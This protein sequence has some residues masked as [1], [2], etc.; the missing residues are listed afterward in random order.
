M[1][2]LR[3]IA[4]VSGYTLLSRVTGFIRDIL[5]AGM[6]GAGTVSDAFFVAFRFPNLFRRLFAEGAFQAAFVPIFAG[7]IETD[8]RAA[9]HLFARRA[10]SVLAVILLVFT[11][12]LEVFMPVV[13]VVIAPGFDAVPGKMELATE[14]TRIAFPYLLFISLVSLQSGV[15]NSLGYFAAAAAAPILLNLTL[16]AALIGLTPVLE[17]SGHALAW[18]V[19]AAGV[20]QFA[21]L[22]WHCRRVGMTLW[23]V[24]PRLTERVRLLGKRVVPVVLGGSLYQINLLI[25]TILASLLADGAV[26]WLYYADRVTQLPLGVVGVAVSTALLPALSRRLKAGDHTAARNDQNRALEVALLLT[27]P[28]AAALMVIPGPVIGTLFERG[29]FSKAD[30][31]ATAGALVAFAT[32]LPSYVLVKILAQAFFARE[33]TVMPVRIAAAAMLANIVLNVILMQVWGHVG[34]ALAASLSNWGNAAALAWVLQR[35]GHLGVDARLRE[36]LPRIVGATALMSVAL[37]AGAWALTD[38][39][40]AGDPWRPLALAGLVAGGVIVYGTAAQ[41]TGAAR[42]DDLRAMLRRRP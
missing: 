29:A 39:L 20:I 25:G 19:F 40:A 5:V 8:G 16:I 11:A 30:T 22:F 21:W 9:A 27:L 31:A 3:S 6:L 24:V 28:A 17:T 7:L 2:L 35:R 34:I 23:P 10:F 32:G 12:A 13:M 4:T 1:A 37:W 36:R 42:F 18:G 41:V 15:L 38:P 33:D 14:L 26:S